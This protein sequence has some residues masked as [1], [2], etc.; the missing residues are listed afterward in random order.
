MQV[1]EITEQAIWDN[2]VMSLLPNTFLQ[3]WQWKL[4]QENDGEKVSMLGFYHEQEL[5]GVA[6][7][8]T[9]H[10]KRGNYFLVPH[11]PI[12]KDEKDLKEVIKQLKAYCV[13]SGSSSPV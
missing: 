4:V 5:C 9:V 13:A 10:A 12:V 6:L 1:K 2:F 3:S 11:G 8:I 7:V